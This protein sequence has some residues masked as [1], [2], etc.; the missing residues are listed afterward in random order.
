MVKS[1]CT[2]VPST[3][4][5]W[6][7]RFGRNFWS[8]WGAPTLPSEELPLLRTGTATPPPA[9]GGLCGPQPGPKNEEFTTE[10][11]V[12]WG[13]RGVIIFVV[14]RDFS[15][16]QSDIIKHHETSMA[17][18]ELV[19]FFQEAAGSVV[20]VWKWGT[21]QIYQIVMGKMALHTVFFLF[22]HNCQTNPD[23]T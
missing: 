14:S 13:I 19:W 10:D 7:P 23:G 15:Y 1:K 8:A 12:I 22:P 3:I 21:P 6:S 4:F 17:T 9:T 5:P 11:G 18:E 16:F 2:I 20:G